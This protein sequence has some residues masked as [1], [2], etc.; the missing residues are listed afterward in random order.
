[1]NGW[2]ILSHDGADFYVTILVAASDRACASG[3]LISE[4]KNVSAVR[5]SRGRH[6]LWML[7]T[8]DRWLNEREV[9]I[10]LMKKVRGANPILRCRLTDADNIA[11]IDLF[12]DVMVGLDLPY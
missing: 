2:L 5:Y 8:R 3:S 11:F 4:Y 12:D 6:K 7:R 1:L 9:N 10:S